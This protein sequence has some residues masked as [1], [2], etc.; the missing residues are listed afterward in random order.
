M[1]LLTASAAAIIC[2]LIEIF[3]NLEEKNKKE[4]I[5]SVFRN[6]VTVPV[7]TVAFMVLILGYEHFLDTSGYR[8]MDY[9]LVFISGIVMGIVTQTVIAFLKGRLVFEKDGEPKRKHLNRLVIAVSLIFVFL[10]VM[11]K[12]G[13]D[14]GTETFGD[15]TGDQLIINLTS[16]TEGTEASVYYGGFEGPV[17]FSVLALVFFS[18]ILFIRFKLV[19][20]IGEKRLTVFNDFFKKLCCLVLSSL[21][22]LYGVRFGI[23]TFRL[24]KV[25]NS[26]VLKSNFIE[27]NYVSPLDAKVKFPEKKRNLIHIYLESMENSFMS[28]DLGG[29]INTNLIPKLTKLGYEGTVFSDTDNY[30]GG[31]LQ[32]T[33]TTWSLA[34]MVNQTMG[35]P[36][37]APGMSNS[38]GS[39]GKFLPGAGSLG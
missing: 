6:L 23:H 26:Y 7:F 8:G 9:F 3:F 4:I 22:L 37:K 31:P 30:F 24:D 25:F 12:T 21:V 20:R 17:F 13:T 35:I 38:Y 18:I 39:D 33:G 2:S 28:K 36:M 16:P 10:G 5:K 1:V 11:A 15:V 29:N 14:W 27:E 19:Y 34:S 32:G